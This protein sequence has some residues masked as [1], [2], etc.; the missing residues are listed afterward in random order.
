MVSETEADEIRKSVRQFFGAGLKSDNKRYHDPQTEKQKQRNDKQQSA[1]ST[2]SR[3]RHFGM[4]NGP[5]RGLIRARGL[6]IRGRP[7]R[8]RPAGLPV[9]RPIFRMARSPA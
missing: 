8:G 7:V 1:L 3:H 9:R 2:L 5:R 6:P 4:S